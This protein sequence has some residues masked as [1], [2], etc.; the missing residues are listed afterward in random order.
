MDDATGDATAFLADADQRWRVVESFVRRYGYVHLQL[1]AY[2]MFMS[3]ILPSIIQENSDINITANNRRHRIRFGDVTV[4]KPTTTDKE[5]KK[6]RPLYPFEARVRKLTY[7]C[8]VVG[9][10]HHEVF[11]EATGDVISDHQCHDAPLL[12]MPCMFRSQSCWYP[13]VDE[14]QRECPLDPGGYFL[15]NGCEKTM[16]GQLKV[17]G[18]RRPHRPSR[19][20]SRRPC[21]CRPR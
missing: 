18:R 21:P 6:T 4:L 9:D 5:T 15:I 13:H 17:G 7:T 8:C 11:D 1:D 3:E 12:Y 14:S 2:N 16:L 19:R 20:P 10:V